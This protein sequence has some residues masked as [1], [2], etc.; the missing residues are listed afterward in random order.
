MFEIRYFV[1][2]VTDGATVYTKSRLFPVTPRN[3]PTRGFKQ[4]FLRQDNGDVK[5]VS[6]KMIEKLTMKPRN[7]TRGKTV[8]HLPTGK[9]Y[10]SMKEACEKNNLS[11]SKLKANKD[12]VISS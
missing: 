8:T 1:D 9:I 5:F 4:Y 2:Y 11:I 10:L 6:R 7:D 12:F 3:H